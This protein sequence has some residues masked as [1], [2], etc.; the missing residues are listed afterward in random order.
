MRATLSSSPHW[1]QIGE[2]GAPSVYTSNLSATLLQ[3]NSIFPSHHCRFQNKALDKAMLLTTKEGSAK[4]QRLNN[5]LE[6]SS[7]FYQ[8]PGIRLGVPL[9]K[10]L[11]SS[12]ELL[13]SP[14][15]ECVIIHFLLEPGSHLVNQQLRKQHSYL[16]TQLAY[17]FLSG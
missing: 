13:T 17:I 6:H 4:Q 14:F 12:I 10:R 3:T 16:V 2:K 5:N 9:K 15:L 7:R 1:S 11:L 8:T